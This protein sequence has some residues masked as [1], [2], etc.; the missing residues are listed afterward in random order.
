MQ[1]TVF[2]QTVLLH[3]DISKLDFEMPSNGPNYNHFHQLYLNHGFF[4]P[5]NDV[6][7]VETE[8]WS[9]HVF[10][11]GW[12][13]KRKLA[14][15]FA[16]GIDISYT[17]PVFSIKQNTNKQ[18]P[19]NIAHAKEKLKFNDLNIEFYTRFNFGKRGNVIGKF[20]DIGAYAGYSLVVKHFYSD[21]FDKNNPPYYSG[22][23]EVVNKDLNYIN[24]FNC[25]LKTRLGINRWVIIA[26]YRLSDLLTD[27]Y[28]ELVG[29]CFFPRLL[30]GFELGLHK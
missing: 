26:S 12:R 21:S 15:W 19:N 14:T 22:K 10:T 13:Y 29:D 6:Q 20:I 17:N 1:L 2:S 30:V 27:D 18:V 3:E 7:E 16:A 28:K 4:I 24:K 5:D 9:S 8:F 25:G 23:K 11:I